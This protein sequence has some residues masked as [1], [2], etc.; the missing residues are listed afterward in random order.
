[1]L[2]A[3]TTLDPGPHGFHLTYPN[4]YK[5]SIQYGIGNYCDNQS[6]N[7]RNYADHKAL[8]ITATFECAIFDSKDDFAVLHNDVAGWILMDSLGDLIKAV[9]Q[10]EWKTVRSICGEDN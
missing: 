8:D 2:E 9:Q 3:R 10:K 6:C 5:L 1:M 4:G 7:S